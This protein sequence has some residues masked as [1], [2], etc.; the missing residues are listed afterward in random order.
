LRKP[1]QVIPEMEVVP[2]MSGDALPIR[3]L[4]KNSK[5]LGN[6]RTKLPNTTLVVRK[7]TPKYRRLAFR[8]FCFNI[9]IMLGIRN[10]RG[11]SL[12]QNPRDKEAA[13]MEFRFL[14]SRYSELKAKKAARASK[15]PHTATM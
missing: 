12:V 9:K 2:Y 7:K 6:K 1:N 14:R 13:L 4:D 10:N 5:P 8:P 11:Y 3:R 15:E